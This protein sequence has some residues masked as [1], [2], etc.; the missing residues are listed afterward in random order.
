MAG[1]HGRAFLDVPGVSLV[2]IWNRTRARAEALAS[3]LGISFVADSIADL[4]ESTQAQLAV[5]AV[6]EPAVNEIA[7]QCFAW[8]WT[9]LMEKPPGLNLTDARDI[10]E[11]ARRRQ[12]QVLVGLNRR[13]LFSTRTA[14]ADL[15]ENACKRFI[16]VNDQEDLVAASALGQP[17]TLLDN[18][19]FANSIHLIDYFRVFGRGR[20][21]AVAPV[22][23]WDPER[24]SIVSAAIEFE[25]G[26]QGMYNC[27]W[28]GPA[29]WSVSVA[30]FSKRWEMRPLEQASFQIRGE[31]LQRA[32]D[33]HPW[34]TQFKPGFRLQA[35]QA[36]AAALGGDSEIPDLDDAV[37]TMRLIAQIY[38]RA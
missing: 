34:D 30:T 3:K 11:V 37:E 10:Q 29:P 9:V 23:R 25:N 36:V 33:T 17:K 20:V 5:V 12:R 22:F 27:V 14:L 31:R 26:D 38:E 15:A 28:N 32:V 8:P 21:K 13:F 1:E 19:M 6:L 18:W 4:F 24:P 16:M 35:A 2:G 7:R